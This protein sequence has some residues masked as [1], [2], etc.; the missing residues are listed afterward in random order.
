MG[1]TQLEE[2]DIIQEMIDDYRSRFK[3]LERIETKD[4]TTFVGDQTSKIMLHSHERF[5]VLT[6]DTTMRDVGKCRW[7]VK[8]LL[9]EYDIPVVMEHTP[10]EYSLVSMS[11]H[12]INDK[13]IYL[14]GSDHVTRHYIGKYLI[15]TWW[16]TKLRNRDRTA[17]EKWIDQL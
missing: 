16:G 13:L 4:T 1:D 9:S 5:R 11:A 3:I 14:M 15:Y 6:L 12:T 8:Y 10:S 2:V 17:I 7:V